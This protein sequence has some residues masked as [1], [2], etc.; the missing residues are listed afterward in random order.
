M[1][2]ICVA[3]KAHLGW[4]NAVGV[5]VNRPAPEPRHVQ[6]VDLFA[7]Q[8]REVVEPYHVAGGWQGLDRVPAP[9]DPARVIAAGRRKQV[10]ATKRRLRAFN[11]TLAGEGFDW[12]R[13]V[14]LTGR[15]WLGHDLDEIITDHAHIH[16]YEGE[17][18]RD[19]ARK[20]LD[21]IGIPWVEQDEKSVVELAARQLRVE[22]ADGLMKSLRPEGARGWAKEERLLGL[23]AWLHSRRI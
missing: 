5:V 10:T 13:S 19:A 8:P 16:V 3:F 17:A 4:L 22:D 15:G 18:V 7:E 1:T 21:A 23:A 12:T 20:A 9:P 6:R 11:A 2:G 14:V